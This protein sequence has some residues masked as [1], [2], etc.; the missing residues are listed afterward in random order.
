MSYRFCFLLDI[1][2][3][4]ELDQNCYYTHNGTS[5][6]TYHSQQ[7]LNLYGIH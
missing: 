2:E 6:Q 4:W 1:T 3:F 7:T 5:E